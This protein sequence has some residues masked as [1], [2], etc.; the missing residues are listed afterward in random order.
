M[1]HLGYQGAVNR[2]ARISMEQIKVLQITQ[3]LGG[4]VQKYVIQL[5]QNLNPNQFNVTGCCSMESNGDSG[6]GDTPFSEAFRIRGIP[7]LVVPMQRSISLWNDFFSLLRI[8]KNIR[9]RGFDIVHAQSSKAGVLARIAARIA[10]VPV[11]IYSPHAFS[12][13]GP[14]RI[15]TKLP[16]IFFEKIASWFCDAIIT[17]SFTEKALA[18]KFKIA[19]EKKIVVVPPGINLQ[20]YPEIS[21]NE[22][23][24]Y[25][26]KLGI[27][28]GH[29]VVAMIGRLA[30]QK[31]P[32]TFILSSQKLHKEYSKVTFLLIGD[33][34]LKDKCL[35]LVREV[36]LGE[37]VKMLGWRRDYKM[38]LSIS[39]VLV[40]TS[41]WEG[42]PFILLEAMACSKP[43]VATR[44]TG[45]LDVI[46]NGENGFLVPPRSPAVLAHK[47][48]LVLENPDVAERIGKSARKTVEEKFG[49]GKMITSIEEVYLQLYQKKKR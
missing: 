8:Y 5:C 34:P 25:R 28:N 42:L 44:T 31:D 48:K 26:E 7:Y 17:D 49:L 36:G 9:Q 27:S 33:G 20:E 38:L 32:I 14:G 2:N 18:L 11:V 37:D 19:E 13:D 22:R 46:N 4:G 45:T 41:L 1:V 40:I 35:N 3:S 21:E 23:R 12:F 30:P 10:G 29:K 6:D 43:V 47:I 16:F 39:D 15:V 24:A